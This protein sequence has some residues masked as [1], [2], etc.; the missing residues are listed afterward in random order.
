VHPELRKP[1]PVSHLEKKL[2]NMGIVWFR[3]KAIKNW[4]SDL[5]E[6]SSVSKIESLVSLQ[7]YI[8]ATYPHNHVPSSS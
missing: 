6:Q 8:P 1:M 4:Y 3:Q 5:D 7:L 2:E